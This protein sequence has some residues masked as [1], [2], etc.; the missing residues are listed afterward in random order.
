MADQKKLCQ[1]KMQVAISNE[2]A[3]PRAKLCN[4]QLNKKALTT[5]CFQ[6]MT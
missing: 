3:K 2:N 1:F 6:T 5:A 4:G